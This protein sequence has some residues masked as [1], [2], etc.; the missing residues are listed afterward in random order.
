MKHSRLPISVSSLF[1]LFSLLL[2]ACSTAGQTTAVIPTAALPVKAPTEPPAAPPTIE[3]TRE[4]QPTAAPTPT[5]RSGISLEQ[6]KNFEFRVPVYQKLVRLANGKFEAGSGTDFLAVNLLD[7]VALGDLDGDGQADAVVLLSENGG[8]SGVFVS[9]LA[10]LNRGGRPQQASAILIDDRPQIT[11]LRIEGDKIILEAVIHGVDD[12]LCCPSFP[13]IET[14]RLG[15]NG[16]ALQR[17]ESITPNGSQ[18][19]IRIANPKTAEE[20]G[21]TVQ[22]QGDVTIA[23]FEN[24]LVYRIYDPAG[25]LLASGPLMVDAANP[26]DPGAFDAAID[27]S[28]IP[29]GTFIRLEVL[30]LSPADGSTLAM[31]SVEL[32]VR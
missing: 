17:V 4:P 11:D 21:G 16:L 23:P 24:N 12:P 20:V 8:G 2:G 15:P 31:D 14:F 30:D 13:V 22:L 27:L 25:N 26:G 10:L 3:P 29:A 9:L 6:L 18:R 1:I 19:A 32:E 5:T 28:A 7:P